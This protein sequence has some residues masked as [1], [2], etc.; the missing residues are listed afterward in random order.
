MGANVTRAAEGLF[1]RSF[2]VKEVLRMEKAGIISEDENY[3]LVEGEIVPMQA[4][5]HVHELI[6]SELNEAL[7]RA[8]PRSLRLGIESTMYL[9]KNTLLEPDIVIYPKLLKL[10]EVKGTDIVLAVEVALTTLSYDRGLKAQLYGRYGVQELWVI[11][12]K[13]R[14]T[15]VHSDPNDGVWR[16]VEKLGP[17][18]DLK[19]VALPEF[20]MRLSGI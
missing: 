8:L 7:V 3:E 13:K 19:C 4:K 2:T 10:E 5:T 16:S 15:Y 6:K 14:L 17:D 12:A 9:S 20:S 18:A 1:R 11:D